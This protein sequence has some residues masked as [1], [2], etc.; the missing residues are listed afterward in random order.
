VFRAV[1]ASPGALAIGVDI[2]QCAEAPG[3]V[4]DSAVKRVD[5]ATARMVEAIAANRAPHQATLGLREGAVG[6]TG[7]D[8]GGAGAC[9]INHHPDVLARVA[10]VRDAIVAGTLPVADPMLASA[11]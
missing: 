10:A 9:L 7:L 4:L 11:P 1:A 8:G 6:L 3:H 5:A 2:D